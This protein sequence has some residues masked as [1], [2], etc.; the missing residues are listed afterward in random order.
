MKIH[1]PNAEQTCNSYE[2]V[3]SEVVAVARRAHAKAWSPGK[4]VGEQTIKAHEVCRLWQ[5]KVKRKFKKGGED[6]FVSEKPIGGSDSRQK[7]DLVDTCMRVAYE[8]KASPNNTHMEVYRDVFKALVFN[9]RNPGEKLRE[10]VF[11]CPEKGKANLGKEFIKDVQEIA[12]KLELRVDL[13]GI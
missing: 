9:V 11:I 10:L 13:R 6:R 3:K 1:R 8:L 2:S 7:I 4:H 5:K 12:E